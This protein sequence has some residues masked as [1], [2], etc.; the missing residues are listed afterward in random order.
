[1]FSVADIPVVQ[2]KH[3]ELG[4]CLTTDHS[5]VYFKPISKNQASFDAVVLLPQDIFFLQCTV[6]SEHNINAKGLVELK[7]Q[8]PQD[9][10]SNRQLHFVFV[11]PD[12][13]PRIKIPQKVCLKKSSAGGE[14]TVKQGK[15]ERTDEASVPA[16]EETAAVGSDSDLELLKEF[17]NVP[18][19]TLYMKY[20]ADVGIAGKR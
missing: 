9:P 14:Q 2:Y 10:F 4:A 13:I 16:A 6:S 12:Q 5:M 3:D 7:K 19:Y 1:M 15:K 11:G 8:C 18:Q 17:A 20:Q